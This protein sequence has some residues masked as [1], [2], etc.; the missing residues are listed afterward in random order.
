MANIQ[1]IWVIFSYFFIT[2]QRRQGV[3]PHMDMYKKSINQRKKKHTKVVTKWGNSL[4][5]RLPMEMNFEEGD[6]V[7][8]EEVGGMILIRKENEELSREGLVSRAIEM[9]EHTL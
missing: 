1:N 6:V 9:L 3:S 5:V 2:A 8:I 7:I 4:A